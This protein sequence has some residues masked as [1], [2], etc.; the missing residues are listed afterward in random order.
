MFEK[1]GSH[2]LRGRKKKSVQEEETLGTR[3]K[4]VRGDY[5]NTRWE[6]PFIPKIGPTLP[7]QEKRKNSQEEK[8]KGNLLIKAPEANSISLLSRKR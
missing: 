7:F 6:F 2:F 4:E 5:L 3:E 1:E 8:K